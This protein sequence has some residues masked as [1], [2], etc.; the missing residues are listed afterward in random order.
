MNNTRN[1][2]NQNKIINPNTILNDHNLTNENDIN[3]NE[4]EKNENQNENQN[5]VEQII[6]DNIIKHRGIRYD[7][8]DKDKIKYIRNDIFN[9]INKNINNT[10]LDL[11]ILWKNGDKDAL[12]DKLYNKYKYRMCDFNIDSMILEKKNWINL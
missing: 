4:H 2:N 5:E 12:K 1:T 11:Y 10:F 7:K 3:K 8:K 9:N 6:E